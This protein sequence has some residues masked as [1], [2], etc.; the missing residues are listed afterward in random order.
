MKV[1]SKRFLGS[2]PTP[3]KY[4]KKNVQHLDYNIHSRFMWSKWDF[5]QV[6]HYIKC[7]LS[8]SLNQTHATIA[9]K[10]QQHQDRDPYHYGGSERHD[11]RSPNCRGHRQVKND[12]RSKVIE[13]IIGHDQGNQQDW[14]HVDSGHTWQKAL[15]NH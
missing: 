13:H 1:P 15:K 3:S 2:W 9:C 5:N 12:F 11:H 8:T 7:Y 6:P 4:N 14:D 10:T